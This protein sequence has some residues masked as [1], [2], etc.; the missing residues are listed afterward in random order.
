MRTFDTKRPREHLRKRAIKAPGACLAS[1]IAPNTW[2][3]GIDKPNL[4]LQNRE[5]GNLHETS[6]KRLSCK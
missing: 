3:V 4:S 1:N 2:S 5:Y 6:D